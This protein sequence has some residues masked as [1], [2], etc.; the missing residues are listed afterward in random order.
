MKLSAL[1]VVVQEFAGYF[2]KL[3]QYV[4]QYNIDNFKEIRAEFENCENLPELTA[5]LFNRMNILELNFN[6]LQEQ[7]QKLQA[8]L[9]QAADFLK[10]QQKII[11]QLESNIQQN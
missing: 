11:Q 3:Y 4:P 9:Q 5:F 10:K 7:N 8:Q 1:E 2:L 6:Q